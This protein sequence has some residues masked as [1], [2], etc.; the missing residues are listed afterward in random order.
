MQTNRIA[1]TPVCSCRHA[2]TVKGGLGNWWRD[3]SANHNAWLAE[4]E[5]RRRRKREL[6]PL[7]PYELCFYR[8]MLTGLMLTYGWLLMGGLS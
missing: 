8:L 4:E 2:T 5:R 1:A 3:I 7:R 6:M